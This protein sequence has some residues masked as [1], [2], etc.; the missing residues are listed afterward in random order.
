MSL[1]S[2]TAFNLDLATFHGQLKSL[3]SGEES[4]FCDVRIKCDGG[5]VAANQLVLAAGSKVFKHALTRYVAK[6]IRFCLCRLR[7]IVKSCVSTKMTLARTAK[8]AT[9]HTLRTR[10]EP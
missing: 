1:S 9:L 4:M 6:F 5:V 10:T 7:V 3:V 2:T 8:H